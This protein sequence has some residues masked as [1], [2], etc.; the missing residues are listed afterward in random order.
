MS[1]QERARAHGAL[2]LPARVAVLEHLRA[3]PHPLDARAL[4]TATGQHV[5]TIRF[6]LDVLIEAGLVIATG[7]RPHG[8]GRPRTLYAPAFRNG[9]APGGAYQELAD[10]LAAHFDTT[11]ARRRRRAERAG[12]DWAARRLGSLPE[13]TPSPASSSAEARRRVTGMFTE[14]GFDPEPASDGRVL[15]HDC[16]F[17]DI[18]RAHP[19]VVCAAH[20]GLLTEL[21]ARLDPS[22]PASTLQPFVRPGVC[23]ITFDDDSAARAG[24][25]PEPEGS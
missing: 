18:A 14:M 5:T 9:G 22:R 16:P 25:Q 8:R 23:L 4:A 11:P 15:L 21:L 12:A 1:V 13:T 7:E 3:S 19:D 24:A 10:V 17:R 20:Q 2:A 6:H